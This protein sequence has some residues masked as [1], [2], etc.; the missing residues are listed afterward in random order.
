MEFDNLVGFD[1]R[2]CIGG[3][4]RRVALITS[5]IFRKYYAP[6]GITDSQT[7]IL[8]I[9]T[10]FGSKTQK[11]LTDITK[12]EKST[13]NRNLARLITNGYLNKENFPKISITQEGK[14][15]VN[16]IIPE[17]KKAM[18]EITKLLTVEGLES[19]NTVH[20]SL[21]SNK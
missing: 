9:L 12:L 13:L 2:L 15:L 10:Q 14:T 6:F 4:V 20:H 8:F 3:K 17:W 19:L 11:E 5:S 18:K 7:S 21:T 1:P 16:N